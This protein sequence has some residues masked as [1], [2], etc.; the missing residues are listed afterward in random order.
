LF[1]GEEKEITKKEK[2]CGDKIKNDENKTDKKLKLDLSL[3]PNR[4]SFISL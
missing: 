3:F 4:G 1:V 2:Q